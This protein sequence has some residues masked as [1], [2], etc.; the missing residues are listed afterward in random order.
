MT[1]LRPTARYELGRMSPERQGEAALLML[2]SGHF[3]SPYIRALV[4]AS[5]PSQLADIKRQP[6]RAILRPRQRDSANREIS[7]LAA[8]L[9]RLRGLKSAD[10]LA[11]FVS[12]QYTQRLLSNPRVGAYIKKK[13][14]VMARELRLARSLGRVAT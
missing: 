2:A 1:A 13:H 3:G 10:L 8:R 9:N 14:P 4:A 5:D 7:G 12:A 11:L 6:R